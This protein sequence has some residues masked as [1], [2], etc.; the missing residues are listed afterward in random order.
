MQTAD[1]NA[2]AYDELIADLYATGKPFD[3]RGFCYMHLRAADAA[4]WLRT[5]PDADFIDM[6]G[7]ADDAL[8]AYVVK[9]LA[10]SGPERDRLKAEFCE[11]LM[12]RAIVAA[13]SHVSQD[14]YAFDP[15]GTPAFLR[16]QA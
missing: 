10:A 9:M 8:Q 5:V 3:D 11:W 2:A 7:L 15:T 6:C 13:A 16:K 12:H 4:V 14:V 1:E